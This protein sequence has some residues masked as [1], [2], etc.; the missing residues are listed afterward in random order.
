MN[1]HWFGSTAP[2][3]PVTRAAMW[4][5]SFPSTRH[6]VGGHPT[7][8]SPRS[9][10]VQ[11]VV[12]GLVSETCM[13]WLTS[14]PRL[15]RPP[16]PAP[17]TPGTAANACCVLQPPCLRSHYS[18]CHLCQLHISSGV[19]QMPNTTPSKEPSLTATSQHSGLSLPCSHW[20]AEWH[21]GKAM[22]F[23]VGLVWF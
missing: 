2:L 15:P 6:G 18:A 3:Q 21:S 11:R 9:S 22:Y 12:P 5:I 20:E 19:I 8:L 13:L 1:Q 10:S 4:L 23:G 17:F 7:H 14:P 16:W